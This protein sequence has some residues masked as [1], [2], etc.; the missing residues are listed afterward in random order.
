MTIVI[1]STILKN[2]R[3]SIKA[4]QNFFIRESTKANVSKETMDDFSES[5][6]NLIGTIDNLN[7]AISRIQTLE[8]G[9]HE[10]IKKTEKEIE[11]TF[12]NVQ[13][14]QDKLSS[15]MFEELKK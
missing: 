9:N 3:A 14:I 12:M 1:T 11:S 7:E 15:A 8:G 10:E 4:M 13:N 2:K 6:A 5:C